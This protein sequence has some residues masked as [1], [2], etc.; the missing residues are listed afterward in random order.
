PI[1]CKR[2]IAAGTISIRLAYSIMAACFL[3]SLIIVLLF[4]NE[5]KYFV[6]GLILVYYVLN[7]AYT[8]F[9]K[10]IAIIDVM[11]I[12]IGFVLRIFVGGIATGIQLS[13]WIIIMTFL[14]ALLLAFAKRRD[15]VVIYEKT[16][17]VMRKN[18]NRYNLA[19]MNQI[20]SVIASVIIIAYLMY[21]LSPAITKQFNSQ[22]VY[23]TSFFVI[24]GIIRY[25]QISIVDSNSENPT[26]ILYRDRFIQFCIIGWIIAFLIIIY[27]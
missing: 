17:I 25:L 21:T 23:L 12:A 24:A 26:K 7:I 20:L 8:L 9:L 22:Y 13:E 3:I 6:S 5:S 4:G 1:K 18:T 19:F 16:G 10:K 15:D 2:P 27:F 14:L 11:V